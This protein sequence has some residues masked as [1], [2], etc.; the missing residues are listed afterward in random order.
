[1]VD[2]AAAVDRGR[3]VIAS[4]L[5]DT[6][7]IAL[8]ADG[9]TYR[10]L[11]E[12]TARLDPADDDSRTLYRGDCL[13]VAASDPEIVVAPQTPIAVG[14]DR[15]LLPYTAPDIPRGAIVRLTKSRNPTLLVGVFYVH[16]TVHDSLNALRAVDISREPPR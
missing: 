1:V 6:C 13:L 8:D 15:L 4:V 16:G 12:G 11:L 3:A 5:V 14:T 9:L 10:P 2:L 7:T